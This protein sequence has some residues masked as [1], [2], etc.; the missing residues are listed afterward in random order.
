MSIL[1]PVLA[2]LVSQSTPVQGYETTWPAEFKASLSGGGL[3]Q[4]DFYSGWSAGGS[5]NAKWYLR[6]PLVDDGTPLSMQGFLQRLDRL[7]FGIDVI[8]FAAKD[9][10]SLYERRGH[11]ANLSLSGLFYLRDLV[12]G[13]GLHYAR[14]YEFQ[15]PSPLSDLTSD[16]RHTTQFAY[17]ELTFGLRS[18]RFEFQ[19]S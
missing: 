5:A 16:E 15:H 18:G 13:A 3:H 17:P 6:R 11:S 19:G 2:L 14:I 8:G 4:P 9:D 7:S 10:L 12:L 1:F